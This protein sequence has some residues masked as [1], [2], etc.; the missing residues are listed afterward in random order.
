[1]QCNATYLNIA[2]IYAYQKDIYEAGFSR[3][4]FNQNSVL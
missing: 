3:Y 4:R 1:M 2:W